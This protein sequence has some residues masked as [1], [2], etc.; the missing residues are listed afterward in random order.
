MLIS[1]SMPLLWLIYA[2]LSLIV[3]GTGYLGLAFLPRLPRLVIT[4]MVAGIM[5]VPSSFSTPIN[6]QGDVYTGMAPAV[7]VAGLAFLEGDGAGMSSALLWV[8]L[9]ALLGGLLGTLVWWRK[10]GSTPSDGRAGKSARRS[11][12]SRGATSKRGGEDPQG[13]QARREPVV[14]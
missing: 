2:A 9:A 7:V 10:R 1:D 6:E 12:S 13:E 11:S 5:W 8:V 4:W 14:G 3:L